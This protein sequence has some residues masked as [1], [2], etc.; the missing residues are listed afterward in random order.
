MRRLLPWIG[1]AAAL[2]ARAPVGDGPRSIAALIAI[3]L[4]VPL[5]ASPLLAA[6]DAGRRAPIAAAGVAIAL[7]F[8]VF[9][10]LGLAGVNL[11][12]LLVAFLILQAGVAILSMRER[13]HSSNDEARESQRDSS[14]TWRTAVLI[15]CLATALL[16]ARAGTPLGPYDDALDHVA[17]IRHVAET[18]HVDFP[19]AFYGRDQPDGQDIRK[20]SVHLGLAMAVRL[21]HVDAVVLWRWAATMLAPLVLVAF[22]ALAGTLAPG[23][24]LIA[25]LALP[26]WILI[27]S[28]PTWLLKSPYGG[29][30]GLALAWA[31]IAGILSGWGALPSFLAGAALAGVHA[32]APAQALV[33]L[34]GFALVK[35]RTGDDPMAPSWRS[36]GALAV[37]ALVI[38][39]G[40]LL[41]AAPSINPLSNQSMPWL[42]TQ[43][44]PIASPLQLLDWY[45]LVGVAAAAAVI[46][47]SFV[48]R[49]PATRYLL[50]TLI[51]PMLLLVNPLLFG[52]VSKIFGSVANKIALVWSPPL[53]AIL[54]MA[55]ATRPDALRATRAVAAVGTALVMFAAFPTLQS[56]LESVTVP[57]VTAPS[58]L[59]RAAIELIER[60]TP[61][62]AVIAADPITSYAIPA[63][64]GRRTIVTLHQ[65]APPG[66]GRALE[67]VAAGAALGSTCA[68]SMSLWHDEGARWVLLDERPGPR[69][70]EYGA[71]R[72][73]RNNGSLASRFDW[74]FHGGGG[75]EVAGVDSAD[76]F[77]LLRPAGNSVP[78]T[79]GPMPT[80]ELTSSGVV[81][82]VAG[83]VELAAAMLGPDRLVSRGAT[84]EI[85][86]WWRRNGDAVAPYLEVQ[87]HLRIENEQMG[88]AGGPFSKLR[89]RLL[90]EPKLGGSLRA[91]G[92]E[93]PFRGLCPVAEWPAGKWLGDTIQIIVPQYIVPGRYKVEL[94]LEEVT[95][96][97]VLTLADLFSDADRYEGPDLGWMTVE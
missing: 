16:A 25:W 78:I 68:A 3:F 42:M 14:G 67:R 11:D 49:R 15:S 57:A 30:A 37:G 44:G 54:L 45:G 59:S 89:R 28:D 66:D 84:L 12:L 60:N 33:P 55:A 91:R 96:Y 13:P 85:P 80:S 50:V 31:A 34:A 41:V 23:R 79:P 52:A 9:T 18:R 71:H 10:A 73:P 70:D 97:P 86:A 5:A 43:L 29:H 83:N 47:L 62:D 69:I 35:P 19:G 24:P 32:Y 53:A 61:P 76:G 4:G 64:T 63:M 56:N 21:A 26:A 95:L 72:D 40:R 38:E 88:E 90:I 1:P 51:A 22:I 8:L 6:A 87:A 20:G 46:V 27:A 74:R 39:G 58:S 48:D 7:P 75:A 17:T 94:S 92:V 82:V 36:L 77:K 93:L 81:Q 65:H 2:L